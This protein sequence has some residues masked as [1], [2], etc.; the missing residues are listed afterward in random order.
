[1]SG[2]WRTVLA[3][4]VISLVLGAVLAG[5]AARGCR[6]DPTFVPTATDIDAGPGETVIAV[7]LDAAIQADEAEILALEDRNARTLAAL[8]DEQRAEYDGVRRGGRHAVA[9]WLS[10]F[11]TRL[12]TDA[13]V[14]P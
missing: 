11:N 4:A 1:M 9:R 14:A 6:P 7:S 12:K 3:V 2:S 10:D 8:N 5:L 13:G